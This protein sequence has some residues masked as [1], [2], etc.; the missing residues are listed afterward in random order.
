M[1]DSQSFT[2]KALEAINALYSKKMLFA[3]FETLDNGKVEL[4]FSSDEF[5]KWKEFKGRGFNKIETVEKSREIW[6]DVLEKLEDHKQPFYLAAYL[7]IGTKMNERSVPIFISF[8]PP[9]SSAVKSVTF[10]AAKELT[11]GKVSP[12]IAFDTTKEEDLGDFDSLV[13]KLIELHN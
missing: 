11:I 8:C 4:I 3:A 12:K 1:T 7:T 6:D 5:E 9:G 13:T 2:S 10:A